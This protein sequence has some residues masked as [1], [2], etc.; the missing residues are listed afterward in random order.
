MRLCEFEKKEVINSC[1]CSKIGYVTDIVFEL[2][3]FQRAESFAFYL[4]RAESM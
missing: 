1:D 4:V 3:L 2:L